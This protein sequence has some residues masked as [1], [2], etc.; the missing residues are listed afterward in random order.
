MSAF[1]PPSPPDAAG[2]QSPARGARFLR[3]RRPARRPLTDTAAA[4]VESILRLLY[5]RALSHEGRVALSRVRGARCEEELT[6]GALSEQSRLLSDALIEQGFPAG[7]RLAILS[8][9]RPEWAI[10]FFA[11]VRAGAVVVPLDP[12]L[13]AADLEAILAD[14]RPELLLVGSRLAEAGRRAQ[15]ADPARRVLRLD[16]GPGDPSLPS[17][18]DCRARQPQAGRDRTRSDTA[19]L[20]YT[21]GTTGRPKGVC[22]SFGSLLFEVETLCRRVPIDPGDVFLSMLPLSHLLEVT[23][24]LLCVLFRGGEVCY[25]DTLL[26]SEMAEAMAGRGVSQMVTV[27]LFLRLLEAEIERAASRA[28]RARSLAFRAALAVAPVLPFAWRRRLFRDV[29]ARLGGRLRCFVVGGSALDTR[30]ESF[31]RRLGLE[32][33]QGYGLTECSPVIAVNGPGERRTGSVGRPLP[34]VEVRIAGAA[35][36]GQEGEILTRGPHL[37]QGYRGAA[38]DPVDAEGWLYTGD[39]G[40]LDEDGYL[41]VTGRLKNLIVLA[42]GQK[43]QPEEVEAALGRSAAIKEACVLP[44]R[45]QEGLLAGTEEVCAVVVPSEVAMRD[46]GARPEALQRALAREVEVRTAG[47]SPHK[48]PARVVVHPGPLPRS[49]AHKVR[50]RPLLEWLAAQG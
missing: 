42:N 3:W 47:L 29:H 44:A 49:V 10:A 48:R 20:V 4:P 35:R 7:G 43:V 24:G 23:G 36:P 18:F 50:R 41:Y 17:V 13:S 37:M 8:E 30:T 31:F 45:A 25:A 33:W 19:L 38:E 2:I 26:P 6:Y 5:D 34:G 14:A 16:R 15:E 9:S 12:K 40:R 39:L 28:G 11:A 21:S 46:H 32:I 27:P 1:S 22:I